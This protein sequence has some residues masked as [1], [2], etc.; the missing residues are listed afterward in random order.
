M[1]SSAGT[2][3]TVTTSSNRPR[4]AR[5]WART[6]GRLSARQVNLLLAVAVGGTVVTGLTSWAIGTG[7]ARWWTALHGTFGLSLLVLAPAKI[8]GSVRPGLRRG[9][10]GR[11]L[12]IAFGFV[13]LATIA[14]GLAHSTGL[15][16]GV[17]Y[18]SSLWTHFLLAFL[19]LPLLVWHLGSRPVRPHRVD[20]DRRLVIGGLSALGVAAAGVAATE[21]AV[22]AVGLKGA[23][24]RFTGSHEVGSHDP[25]A[26]PTVSWIDDTAPPDTDPE[27][28]PLTVDGTELAV[29]RLAQ[30]ARPLTA[31]LDCTGGWW[32]EQD[33]SVVPVA[34]LIA[35][36]LLDGTR[37]SFVVTS[38][39]GYR[40]VFPM[41]DAAS[42][43]LAV[44]YGGQPLRRGHGAPVRLVAPARRGPWWVKWVVSIEATDR[45]WWLQLPFPST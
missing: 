5:P 8:T 40:R 7:W 32:S 18:W 9:R 19:S 42:T 30:D 6:I 28:W 39:T 33:W 31:T 3:R 12:S 37:R 1:A 14:L 45:P 25:L 16:T 13:I 2:E 34:E 27:R 20:T 21:G 11:G 36:G 4:L 15:W 17:G 22:R 26:M 24:R 43:H 35:A 41:A 29:A 38:E 23:D 44:G 10:A